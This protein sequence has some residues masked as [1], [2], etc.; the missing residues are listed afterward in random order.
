MMPG[1]QA[2]RG[3]QKREHKE[4]KELLFPY[5]EP[6]QI[7]N[8]IKFLEL[9]LIVVIYVL[10]LLLMFTPRRP[11]GTCLSSS[12]HRLSSWFPSPFPEVSLKRLEASM[13]PHFVFQ[14]RR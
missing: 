2:S 10:F 7:K 8:N 6:V 14:A 12:E 1:Q 13:D 5:Y 9:E 4:H 11:L 3:E